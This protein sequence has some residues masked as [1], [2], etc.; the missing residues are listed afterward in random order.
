MLKKNYADGSLDFDMQ[1][2]ESLQVLVKTR[3]DRAKKL[4]AEL[5]QQER[6]SQIELK[7]K[8]AGTDPSSIMSAPVKQRNWMDHLK[9]PMRF[10]LSCGCLGK[11]KT[12]YF[13]CLFT[14]M[15]V[16]TV[17]FFKYLMLAFETGLYAQNY[18]QVVSI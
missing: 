9:I 16:D 7:L 11:V 15:V 5:Q 8:Q 2:D 1:N 12:T 6:L 13:V 14:V 10:E 18:P 17:N 3:N 4:D